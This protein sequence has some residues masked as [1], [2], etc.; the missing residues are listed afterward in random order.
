MKRVQVHTKETIGQA[1]AAIR[2]TVQQQQP[3]TP[4]R[5]GMVSSSAVMTP[6]TPSVEQTGITNLLNGHL[7]LPAQSDIEPN[8]AVVPSRHAQPHRH[9]HIKPSVKANQLNAQIDRFAERYC[10]A[11]GTS[12]SDFA[13]P[14]QTSQVLQ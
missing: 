4:V 9:M 2:P 7:G 6:V 3:N 1:A 12:L 5:G 10:E 11:T 13:H 8:V 14:A